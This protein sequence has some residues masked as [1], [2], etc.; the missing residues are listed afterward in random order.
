MN[1]KYYHFLDKRNL[2]KYESIKSINYR[3]FFILFLFSMNVDT[4]KKYLTFIKNYRSSKNNRWGKTSSRFFCFLLLPAIRQ[5]R[6]ATKKD[7][8]PRRLSLFFSSSPSRLSSCRWKDR[9]RLAFFY[10]HQIRKWK[11]RYH[12]FLGCIQCR[13]YIIVKIVNWSNFCCYLSSIS[14]DEWRQIS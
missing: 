1:R 2:Y 7:N 10:E 4:K 6:T 12:T 9:H 13:S 5:K 14:L 8:R 11:A 3:D